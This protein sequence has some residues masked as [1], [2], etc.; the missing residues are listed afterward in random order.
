MLVSE[1]VLGAIPSP[2]PRNVEL[3]GLSDIPV[4][5]GITE[6]EATVCFPLVGGRTDYAGFSG[7]DPSFLNWAKD[8]F[9]YYWDKG[10]RI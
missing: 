1:G 2:S 10:K 6:K 7:K 3:R 4:T 8:L 9:L 5:I